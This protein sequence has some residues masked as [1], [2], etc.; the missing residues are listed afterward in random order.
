MAV[1]LL[2]LALL[3]AAAIWVRLDHNRRGRYF[4]ETAE[5]AAK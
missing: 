5:S 1:A 3:A 2:A 4:W